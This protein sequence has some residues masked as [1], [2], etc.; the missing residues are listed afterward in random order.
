MK[1]IDLKAEHINKLHEAEIEALNK[2]YVLDFVRTPVDVPVE[3]RIRDI[4]DPRRR[5]EY[6]QWLEEGTNHNDINVVS[7]GGVMYIK[8]S[9]ANPMFCVVDLK[10]L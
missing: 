5:I 9:P 1:I 2:C 3:I 8:I 4:D 10:V 6:V 7:I